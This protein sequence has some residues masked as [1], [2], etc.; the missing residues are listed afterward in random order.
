M[1]KNILA[2][3]TNWSGFFKYQLIWFL[4][5]A[6]LPLIT[7]S[8]ISV[9]KIQQ[10]IIHHIKIDLETIAD[11]KTRTIEKFFRDQYKPLLIQ[12]GESKICEMIKDLE[13]F[14]SMSGLS[15]NEFVKSN[16]WKYL[17]QNYSDEF[18]NIVN[19]YN[20]NNIYIISSNGDILYSLIYEKDL[21]TNIFNGKFSNSKFAKACRMTN[22]KEYPHFSDFE[23]YIPSKGMSVA[24]W[25]TIIFDNHNNKIGLLAAQISVDGIN[26][27]MH[28]GIAGDEESYMIGTDLFVRSTS[29]FSPTKN[30][31]TVKAENLQT[32]LW[33]E[34]IK[35]SDVMFHFN[36]KHG[37]T[38]FYK[39][40]SGQEVLGTH[41]ELEIGHSKFAIITETP[42]S[43]AFAI[44]RHQQSIAAFIIFIAAIIVIIVAFFAARS[45]SA[46]LT[47]LTGLAERV[48]LGDLEIIYEKRKQRKDE[49]GQVENSFAKVV[50]SLQ[51][52]SAVCEEISKGIF[53][54]KITIK[55]KKDTLAYSVNSMI[56]NFKSIVVHANL[57]A[58]GDYS[59]NIPLRCD[60]D[61]I[62]LALEKMTKSLREI[63]QINSDN[64]W[65][66]SGH[67]QLAEK[68]G[69]GKDVYELSRETIAFL[70]KYLEC[71]VGSFYVNDF[72]ENCLIMAGS[73]ALKENKYLNMRFNEGEG[74]IGEAA[75][76]KEYII[77]KDIPQDYLIIKS[78][79]GNIS[80]KYLIAMPLIL[81]DKVKAVI[82][83]GGF[84]SFTEQKIHFLNQVKGLVALAIH[85]AQESQKT[86]ELLE[87]T[88]VQSNELQV[89]QE[90]LREANYIMKA[91][92]EELREAN[93]K[94]LQQD[95][96]LRVTN[97]ELI[98]KS[99]NLVKQKEAI[100]QRNQ[101]LKIARKE[102]IHKARELEISN[103]YKSEFLAN[104][105]HEL[106]TPL[107][108]LLLIS[109]KL[110]INKEKNLTE[111][112][113]ESAKIIHNSGKELLELI[114]DILD[115]AKIEAGKMNIKYGTVW[116]E[117]IKENLNN[118]FITSA[119]EKGLKFNISISEELPET[120]ISDRQ[121]LEQILRN[122]I[123]NAIKFTEKG[124]V[125]VIISHPT[126]YDY[127]ILSSI[128]SDKLISFKIIDTGIGIPKEDQLMIFKA[129][130]QV[131]GTTSRKYGGTGLGLSIS[132]DLANLIGGEII[133][134]SSEGK[135]STFTLNLPISPDNKKAN[136]K[137]DESDYIKKISRRINKKPEIII[138]QEKKI[139]KEK[140]L[141]VVEDDPNLRKI[142]K[143][144]HEFETINVTTC[145]TGGEAIK[146]IRNNSFDCVILDLLLPDISGF[147]VLE[148]ISKIEFQS[149][150]PV[151]VYTGKE[152]NNN[153]GFALKKY[154]DSVVLKGPMSYE[155]LLDET[156]LFLHS[157]LNNMNNKKK[158][159]IKLNKE[160]DSFMNGKKVLIVD[161]DM[162]N[163]FALSDELEDYKLEVFKATN[164]KEAL[165]VLNESEEIDI[166]IMDIMMPEMDGYE[167]IKR[168]R[169]HSKYKKLPILALTAKAMKEDRKRCIGAGANDYFSK[170]V[171]I[172]RLISTMRVWLKS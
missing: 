113:V 105:S 159:R 170:P 6:L 75:R 166:V 148:N 97:S 115:L 15:A 150:P 18:A 147:E 109:K 28:K 31:L 128:P 4:C 30:S 133:L 99:N 92:T 110:S 73:Y 69:G 94:L 158:K 27:I 82:E 172:D 54:R 77:I 19:T 63:T 156:T 96:E 151:V 167:A 145:G 87:K 141:L 35:K 48:A 98:E 8:I 22:E 127:S 64:D 58:Q 125:S 74:L 12:A 106:R 51:E 152:L 132:K 36:N 38:F 114:N 40:L 107:N 119:E 121:R 21:G 90:E 134:Y 14:H 118:L 52:V 61:E 126:D 117:Y 102:L 88:K 60:Q 79:F 81:N 165:D 24:F 101:E 72:K 139:F 104:M 122:L 43:Q 84:Q 80:P 68:M 135:G 11:L 140:K 153:E 45:I 163:L 89:Q 2:K 137:S 112:Q 111:K 131:D 32:K 50:N 95:E 124:S 3:K 108:S 78:S 136:D 143:E 70:V 146:L 100:E 66:K 5:I 65:L 17:V 62:G 1:L 162:R 10:E 138:N 149:P 169:K 55:S 83:L 116:L 123:G 161:D 29:H 103:N 57:V 53:T 25:V 86:S 171:D 34:E 93:E 49:F 39:G 47:R 142:V 154:A 168:I 157:V 46:P 155:K 91:K 160:V 76:K 41:N 13:L 7:V 23:L 42:V 59:Q 20:Y 71:S 85:T 129:F 9:K 56:D 16:D 67:A 44:V 26:R 120:I 164:G 33:L 37:E 130:Q 144:L